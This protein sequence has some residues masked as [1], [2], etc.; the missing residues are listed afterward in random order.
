[1]AKIS[2][3]SAVKERVRVR[4]QVTRDVREV[5]WCLYL[6]FLFLFTRFPCGEE[7][8]FLGSGRWVVEGGFWL[9]CSKC[10]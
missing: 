4:Y 5:V 8:E 10:M 2:T 9:L 7:I 3:V 1:V 6:Y